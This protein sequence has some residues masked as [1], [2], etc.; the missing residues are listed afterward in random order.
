MDGKTSRF[1][2]REHLVPLLNRH[3][4]TVMLV[5]AVLF[6]LIMMVFPILYTILLSTNEW[7]GVSANPLRFAGLHNYVNL[8]KDTRFLNAVWHTLYY[9][10]LAVA[11]EL[12]IGFGMAM[13]FNRNFV[14]RGLART[15]F[16]LPIMATPVAVSLTWVM[17]MDPTTGLINFVLGSLG[18][19]QPLWASATATVIPSLVI[20]DIWKWTPLIMLIVLAGLSALPPEPFE[21]AI[22]DGARPYQMLFHITIPLVKPAI[23]VALIFRTIDAL[24]TFDIIFVITGGGPGFASETLNIFTFN[25]AF[26]YFHLGY[27]SAT[28]ILFFLI[29]L[30]IGLVFIKLRR[31]KYGAGEVPR[32]SKTSCS[33][34]G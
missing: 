24:K 21:S 22:I 18:L 5:P 8:L 9:T 10:C 11:L 32:S 13:T 2:S 4:R 12:V 23:M 19:P 31:A 14:G 33:P 15:I 20:V 6:M 1:F 28:L 34:S 16:L 3:A 29:I 26:S 17:L 27:A 30:A 25:Q 7:V